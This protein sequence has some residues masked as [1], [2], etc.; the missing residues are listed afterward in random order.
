[1]TEISSHFAEGARPGS[2]EL[3]P[4]PATQREDEGGWW[5]LSTYFVPETLLGVFTFNMF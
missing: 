1:M 2:Q 4:Y 3:A 5:L